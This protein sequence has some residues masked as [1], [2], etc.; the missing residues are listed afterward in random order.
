MSLNNPHQKGV[1]LDQDKPR[2]AHILGQFPRA[3][4]EVARVGTYGAMKYTDGGWL[5]VEN[6][7]ERYD[8]A[9]LRHW[10]LEKM[11]KERDEELPVL[12]AAQEAWNALAR[13]E[14][15]LRETERCRK[16]K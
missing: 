13:L 12:H 10:L 6:G 11:G 15:I 16:E 14:L 9:K 7:I 4:W 2:V 3:L 8:D 5:S 1:K